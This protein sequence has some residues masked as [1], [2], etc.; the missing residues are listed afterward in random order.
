MNERENGMSATF[1]KE[2]RAAMRAAVAEAKA[3]KVGA[4]QVVQRFC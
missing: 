3:A 2:E 4:D 1:S